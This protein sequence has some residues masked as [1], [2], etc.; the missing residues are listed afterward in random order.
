MISP[1]IGL[2]LSRAENG[3]AS[4]DVLVLATSRPLRTASAARAPKTPRRDFMGCAPKVTEGR[5]GP[6]QG[7]TTEM[8]SNL[9]LTVLLWHM[10]RNGKRVACSRAAR[11][12]RE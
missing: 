8:T 10:G 1:T 11:T 3:A 7:G 2:R 9:H 12:V 6:A 4:A 5:R